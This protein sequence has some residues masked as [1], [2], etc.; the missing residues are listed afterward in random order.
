MTGAIVIG[1]FQDSF[2]INF[3]DGMDFPGAVYIGRSGN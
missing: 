1:A 2:H 3:L